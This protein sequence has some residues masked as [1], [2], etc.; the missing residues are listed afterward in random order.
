LFEVFGLAA[1]NQWF[2]DSAFLG[3]NWNWQLSISGM[4][5]NLKPAGH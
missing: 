2:F 1:W 3:K 4:C 5:R